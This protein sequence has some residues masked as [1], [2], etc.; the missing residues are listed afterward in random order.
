[1]K[2]SVLSYYVILISLSIGLCMYACPSFSSQENL[3][4]ERKLESIIENIKQKED[5]LETFTAKFVQI[6]KTRLLQEPLRS[7]GLIYFDRTGKMLWKVTE[8]SP[9]VVLITENMLIIDYPDLSKTRKISL[10]NGDNAMKRYF[11][12]GQSTKQ[13][14]TN[15]AIELVSQTD[16][17]TCHLKLIPRKKAVAKYIQTIEV[18]VSRKSWLPEQIHFEEVTGDRTS[19]SIYFTLVNGGLPPGIFSLDRK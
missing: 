9:L 3:E 8:P 16:P 10:G 13:L 1:M 11:G 6:K 14:K 12:I 18:V 5:S 15:Y 17:D 2:R 4:S 7:E 19:L